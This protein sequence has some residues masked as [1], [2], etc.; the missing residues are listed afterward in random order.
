MGGGRV[1]LECLGK[2]CR[3]TKDAPQHWLDAAFRL[4]QETGRVK[5]F[6]AEVDQA[7]KPVS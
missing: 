7:L 2:R 1:R 3:F 5:V 4:A 6:C